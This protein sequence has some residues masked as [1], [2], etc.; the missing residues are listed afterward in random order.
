MSVI[1]MNQKDERLADL[2]VRTA[3]SYLADRQSMLTA[4]TKVTKPMESCITSSDMYYDA[5]AADPEAFVFDIDKANAVLDEAGWTL[6]SDGIREKDGKKLEFEIISWRSDASDLLVVMM[7]AC[8]QAGISLTMKT[9]DTSLFIQRVF[10][11][12]EEDFELAYNGMTM[13]LRRVVTKI[14]TALETYSTYSNSEVEDLF[15]QMY[16]STDDQEEHH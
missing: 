4:S 7:D 16:A 11:T 3:L 14:C 8:K 15:A 9:I 1:L 2:A 10:T 6:G 5:T 13:V 12:G